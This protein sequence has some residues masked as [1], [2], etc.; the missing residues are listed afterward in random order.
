MGWR[1]HGPMP[2]VLYG[3]LPTV[4]AASLEVC[5]APL[6]QEP[7]IFQ[8]FP[9]PSWWRSGCSHL[10]QPG[11]LCCPTLLSCDLQFNFKEL[12]GGRHQESFMAKAHLCIFE[13]E[14]S[15]NGFLSPEA[16]QQ[17]KYTQGPQQPR[18]GPPPKTGDVCRGGIIL[19]ALDCWDIIFGLKPV[20]CK[21]LL[22]VSLE[23]ITFFSVL[24]ITM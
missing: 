1:F 3:F 15:Q 22:P 11:L 9:F 10:L 24:V 21:F 14:S 7:G 4:L 19:F 2:A 20:L 16:V 13:Q 5:I 17:L 23:P 18:S 6:Q 8:L 12:H